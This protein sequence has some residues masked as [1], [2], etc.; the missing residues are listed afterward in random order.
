M[1]QRNEYGGRQVTH[2][3]LAA[4]QRHN[5]YHEDAVNLLIQLGDRCNVG[6]TSDC[7]GVYAST[8]AVRRL[9]VHTGGR[10][11]L[12][13]GELLELLPSGKTR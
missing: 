11:F 3:W 1:S 12:A 10:V 6:A 4:T 7:A 5:G 13:N 9:Q 2:G 8:P